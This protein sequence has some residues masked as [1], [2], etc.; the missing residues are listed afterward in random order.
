MSGEAGTPRL[1]FRLLGPFDV[2]R[3][4]RS[5]DLGAD[6][7]RALLALLVLHANEIIPSGR[8]IEE[9]WG[10]RPPD[11]ARNMVQVYVSRL[12]KVLGPG[13]LVTQPPGS[14][15]PLGDPRG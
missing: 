15:L 6:R 7:Q 4:G 9:L 11:S 8:L 1:E 3:G 13:L 5:I 12:R 10:E 14:A 2:L